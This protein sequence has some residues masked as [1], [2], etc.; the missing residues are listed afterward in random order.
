MANST[1][2]PVQGPLA[3]YTDI[4]KE[5]LATETIIY[6]HER[7][8]VHCLNRV[9]AFVLEQC[10]GHTPVRLMAE[11]LPDA[12]KLPPDQDIILL[13][14]RQ[15]NR[16]HLLT[17]E[18]PELNSNTLPSRRELARRFAYVGGVMLPAVASIV[19]P[20]PAMAGSRDTHGGPEN[21]DGNANGDG[22]GNGNGN[23]NRNGNG[24]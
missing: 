20:T 9:L 19:A 14:L 7:H 22:N 13:A 5:R 23:G 21:G 15:L 18:V 24:K 11:R 16:I 6:D 2:P 3:R 1:P 10:D 8:R 4:T 12:M 17:G